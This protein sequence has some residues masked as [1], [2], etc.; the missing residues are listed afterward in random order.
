V[1]LISGQWITGVVGCMTA[2]AEVANKCSDDDQRDESSGGCGSN[3]E[4]C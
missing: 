1:C 2:I 3:E 4:V